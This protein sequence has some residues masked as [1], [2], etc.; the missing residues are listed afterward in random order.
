MSDRPA[1]LPYRSKDGVF[2][3]HF[4]CADADGA[5]FM[6]FFHKA[7]RWSREADNQ[8]KNE[9]CLLDTFLRD[10]L[11]QEMLQDLFRAARDENRLPVKILLVNPNSSYAEARAKS[12]KDG[13]ALDRTKDGLINL[14]RS[15]HYISNIP[16]QEDLNCLECNVLL[17]HIKQFSDKLNLRFYSATPSGPMFFFQD[18]LL[19]GRYCE[20]ILAKDLPWFMI[21]NDPHRLQDLYDIFLSEFNRIWEQSSTEFDNVS[22]DSQLQS[23]HTYFI[24]YSS[25]DKQD[26]D[27]IELLLR[28]NHCHI[29]RD[30]HDIRAG[31][32][33]N[34]EI[35]EA[36]NQSNTVLI[37]WSKNYSE[38]P[39]CLGEF[40]YALNLK[41]GKRL[42]SFQ[43]L[44]TI[45]LDRSE[46]AL[47]VQG[48]L[49]L[50]G[51]SR[52]LR[53][54]AIEQIVREESSVK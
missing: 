25:K 47:P 36:I 4:N 15:L 18:I 52:E 24:S 53:E 8:D 17:S 28:R 11:Y 5:S 7:V 23:S 27:H 14:L 41:R 50:S 46:P 12:L 49:Y 48:F 30:E 43:R 42:P 21:V 20:G 38:S 39:W 31:E 6:N 44:V 34:S 2:E 54:K 9:Y 3:T 29:K 35:K 22:P 26:A 33:L 45:Q 19:Y 1:W 16:L 32:P 37:L 10:S 13:T 40:N 51:Q